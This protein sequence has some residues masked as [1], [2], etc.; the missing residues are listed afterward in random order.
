MC[1]G[2]LT[3]RALFQQEPAESTGTGATDP[4][5]ASAQGIRLSRRG[6]IS[7]VSLPLS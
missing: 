7:T 6:R 2:S 1:Q 4:E 3:E 5:P